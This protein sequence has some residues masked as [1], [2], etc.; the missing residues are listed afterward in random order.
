MLDFRIETIVQLVVGLVI[1]TILIAIAVYVLSKL[2]P[3]SIQS[4]PKADDLLAKFRESHSEGVLSDDEYR[5]IKTT[6]A[7]DVQKEA[8]KE[9]EK[10]R[11]G[12]SG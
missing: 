11:E 4:E 5:T 2:R 9:I 8:D 3:R 12:K 1:A 7:S 6:L 10:G